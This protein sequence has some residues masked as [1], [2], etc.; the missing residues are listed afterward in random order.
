MTTTSLENGK[1]V[2]G[3]SIVFTASSMPS[4]SLL[5][6]YLFSIQILHQLELDFTYNFPSTPFHNIG[7]S[8]GSASAAPDASAGVALQQDNV[9]I[10]V[11][12]TLCYLLQRTDQML[13][14]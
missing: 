5:Q 3:G 9:F 6:E 8:S 4:V 13:K 7:Y 14:K 1:T 2:G 12:L 11:G 10:P